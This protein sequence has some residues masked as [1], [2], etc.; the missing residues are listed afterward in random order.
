[1]MTETY[2]TPLMVSKYQEKKQDVLLILPVISQFERKK[3]YIEKYCRT[4]VERAYVPMI[5]CH[6]FR[7][8]LLIIKAFLYKCIL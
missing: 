7:K 3:K 8:H 5:Y 4:C 6:S 2:L 1:M